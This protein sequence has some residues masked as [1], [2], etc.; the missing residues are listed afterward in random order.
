MKIEVCGRKEEIDID[1]ELREIFKGMKSAKKGQNDGQKKEMPVKLPF[2]TPKST[3][4]I[5]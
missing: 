5:V 3:L 1:E 4:K 2:F